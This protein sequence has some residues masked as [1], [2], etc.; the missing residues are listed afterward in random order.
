MNTF[1]F[2][3]SRFAFTLIELLVVIAIVAILTGLF[4]PAVQKVRE[5]AART[6]CANSL[7]QVVL[8]AHAAHDVTQS[9]PPGLGYWPGAS[10]YG[11][12]HFHLLPFIEQNAVYQQSL[13]GGYYFVGNN[14]VFSQPIKTYVCPADPSAPP[15]GQAK[16]LV[17]NLWGVASYA[18]NAQVVAKVDCSGALISPDNRAKF[19]CSFPD[20]TSTTI[21]LSEKYA[22]CFDNNYPAGGS[23]WAYY[24]TGAGLQPYHAGFAISWNGYSYGPASKFQSQPTP[25][26]GGCDPTLASSPHTGGIQSAMADGSLRFLSNRIT[27]YTWWY[28][29]TPAGREVLPPD[30][31]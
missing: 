17:G 20:G 18:A 3:R 13:Y 26:N 27:P 5:S 31:F 8:A 21:L 1:H 11:T 9:L 2:P 16:D 23:Y 10:E 4:M 24:F 30:A 28:M 25:Y 22:Q 7:R 15:D 19:P 29:C 14:G 6:K 12:F